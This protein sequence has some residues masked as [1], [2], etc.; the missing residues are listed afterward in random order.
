[1]TTKP[2]T[3]IVGAGI[4]GAA[5]AEAIT[6]EGGRVTIV[7]GKPPGLGSTAEGMGHVVVMDDSEAQ[8]AL[9]RFSRELWEAI[10]PELPDRAEDECTGTLWVAEDDEEMEAVHAKHAFYGERG[11]ATEIVDGARLRELEPNLRTDL[12]GALRVLDDRVVYPPSACE[13]FVERARRRG[14]VVRIGRPVVHAGEGRVTLR[15]GSVIEGDHVVVAAGHRSL[16]IVGEAGSDFKIRPRKGHLVITARYQGFCRHQLVELGY[17]KS[18]HTHATTSVAFNLQPRKT[19]QMLLGSSRQY[20]SEDRTV[21]PDV[22]RAM[23]RRAAHYVPS[24]ERLLAIRAWTGFRAATKDKLPLIGP[25]P[26]KERLLL[27][28]GHEG[29]GI[30]TSLGTAELV[31]AHV[32]GRTPRFDPQP[33]LPS[34]GR[35]DHD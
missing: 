29:L 12:R 35:V 18:A 9:T 6:R 31:A 4:V 8:F 11:V 13:F 30:T 20:G 33:Y 19:G 10:A 7:D 34:A 5:C 23:I 16:G 22:L 25:L 24:I 28:A 21:E 17:L 27:A 15:D 14:A 26:G 1:M 32:L 3:I 2:H